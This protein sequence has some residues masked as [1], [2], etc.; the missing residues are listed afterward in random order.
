MKNK[1]G[2]LFFIRYILK[3]QTNHIDVIIID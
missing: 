3:V 1:K 2:K